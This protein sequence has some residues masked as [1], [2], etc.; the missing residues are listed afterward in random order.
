M[1]IFK[2]TKSKTRTAILKYFFFNKEGKYYLRQLER[3][4]DIPVGNIRRELISLSKMGLFLKEKKGK[5]VYYSLNKKLAIFNEVSQIISKTIGIEAILTHGLQKVEGIQISFI[6]G[7]VARGKED[8]LSDADVFII[9]EVEEDAVL[10]AV[11]KI[12]KEISRE[13]N[14][15]I[16]TKPDLVKGIKHGKVFLKDII[17]GKKIFLIGNN[18][19]LEKIVRRK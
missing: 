4:L 2:I 18:N 6:Y 3:T 19:D 7:S 16:F 9:G 10:K 15:T 1:D 17:K 12:E 5:E 14:Y 8:E 11:R 13:V